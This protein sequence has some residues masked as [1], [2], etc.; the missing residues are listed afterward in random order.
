MPPSSDDSEFVEHQ[1]TDVTLPQL[2][3]PVVKT[4]TT[5]SRSVVGRLILILVVAIVV[6]YVVSRLLSNRAEPLDPVR[7][8]PSKIQKTL[9]LIAVPFMMFFVIFVHEL[10]HIIGG[11]LAG[12]RFLLLIVGP[13]KVIRSTKGLKWQVNTAVAL[14]GG[15]ACC[16]PTDTSTFLKSYRWMVVGGPIASLLLGAGCFTC[17][18][19]VPMLPWD[20]TWILVVNR[21]LRMTGLTSI[22]I[23]LVTSYPGTVGNMKSDGKQ[24]LELLKSNPETKRQNLV[25]LLVGQSLAGM[26]PSEWDRQVVQDLDDSYQ[27]FL[28]DDSLPLQE[29]VVWATMRYS[30]SLADS[31]HKLAHQL[32]Q[33]A[34]T[35]CNA[36][37]EFARGSIFLDAALFEARIRK[38]AAATQYLLENT[39][40]G[41]LVEAYMYSAV[42]AELCLLNADQEGAKKFAAEAIELSTSALDAGAAYAECHQLQQILGEPDRG[43]RG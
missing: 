31:D 26:T 11:K 21:G 9:L 38:D 22:L 17:T 10:G 25:R 2:Q 30:V 15:L 42:K 13:L 19:I 43:P 7:I 41:S 8:R 36:Y 1:T 39:P 28:Q 40:E 12:L 5:E 18:W 20:E 33:F 6:G 37:P 29:R 27:D 4:I 14:M 3:P 32:I 35:N 24:F 23:F 34:L 16:S